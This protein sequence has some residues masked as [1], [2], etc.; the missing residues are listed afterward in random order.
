MQAPRGDKAEYDHLK[1]MTCMTTAK[2]I[3]DLI[4]MYYDS[5]LEIHTSVQLV[6][7]HFFFFKYFL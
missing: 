5:E 6:F 2:L 3:E 7:M 1:N 4:Y